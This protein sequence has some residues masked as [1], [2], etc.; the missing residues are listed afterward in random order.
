MLNRLTNSIVYPW[1]KAQ[2]GTARHYSS[3]QYI[4]C[5]WPGH[6]AGEIRRQ[7]RIRAVASRPAQGEIN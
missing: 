3:D 4:T 6:D 2:L 1:P 5:C 7:A